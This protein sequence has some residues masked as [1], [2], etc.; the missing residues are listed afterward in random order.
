VAH[1]IGLPSKLQTAILTIKLEVVVT[2][3]FEKVYQ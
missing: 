3:L 1:N 2:L